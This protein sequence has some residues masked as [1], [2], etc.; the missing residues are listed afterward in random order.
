MYFFNFPPPSR[1][2][3]KATSTPLSSNFNKNL[4]GSL[5]KEDQ[6]LS[7]FPSVKCRFASTLFQFKNLKF[8][9]GKSHILRHFIPKIK[10]EK[11]NTKNTK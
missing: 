3:N 11:Q 9:S 1:I 8:R 4:Q 6:N 2:Q 10:I 7:S 5:F